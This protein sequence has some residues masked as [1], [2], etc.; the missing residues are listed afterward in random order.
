MEVY[1]KGKGKKKKTVIQKRV[2]KVIN[3]ESFRIGLLIVIFLCAAIGRVSPPFTVAESTKYMQV[4]V[5]LART[6]IYFYI[7]IHIYWSLC[8][9]FYTW[10]LI[11]R[12]M[13]LC[14]HRT[15]QFYLHTSIYSQQNIFYIIVSFGGF[16]WVTS[17]DAV[18]N[19]LRIGGIFTNIARLGTDCIN[20]SNRSN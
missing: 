14:A 20:T 6:R 11:D 18:Q 13:D 8:T 5:Y 17:F 2:V 3:I 10:T 1:K 4:L 19:F 16:V 9:V 7:H 15:R 12:S